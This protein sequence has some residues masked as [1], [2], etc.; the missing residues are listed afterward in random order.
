MARDAH[1]HPIPLSEPGRQLVATVAAELLS[2]LDEFSQHIDDELLRNLPELAATPVEI[3]EGLA[4]STRAHAAL[5]PGMIGTWTDP[6]SV[7]APPE[8]LAWAIDIGRYGLPVETLLRAYRVGHAVISQFWLDLLLARTADPAI[9]AEASAATT[10][11]LFAYVD[12]ILQPIIADYVEERERRARESQSVR[13]SELRRLLA[14]EQVDVAHASSRLGYRLDRWHLGFAAWVPEGDPDSRHQLS[15]AGRAMAA[16]LGVEEQ[17]LTLPAAHHV[18]YGWVGSW[19]EPAD[20]PLPEFDGVRIS[21]GNPGRGIEG[22]RHSH[23]QARLARGLAT[24]HPGGG[25]STLRYRDCDVATLLAADIDQARHFVATVLGPLDGGEPSSQKLL[26]TVA[27]YH[28]EGLSITRTAARLGIHPNT[29]TYRVRRVLDATGE[30]DSGSLRLR[31]A[32]ELAQ[33]LCGVPTPSR[34]SAK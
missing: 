14:G 27:I 10:A 5:F 21:S 16:A 28:Q 2:R 19:S 18:L 30:T 13:E 20:I 32:V 33:Y 7:T 6:R 31:A 23:E 1:V 11:Y 17:P 9:L 3:R 22:F 24:Q 26:D 12:A 15:A 8:A 4:R 29:V 25:P 34:A